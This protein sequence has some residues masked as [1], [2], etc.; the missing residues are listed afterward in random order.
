MELVKWFKG[1]EG[2]ARKAERDQER[3]DEQQARNLFEA[4]KHEWF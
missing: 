3:Y 2:K 4:Y 1:L